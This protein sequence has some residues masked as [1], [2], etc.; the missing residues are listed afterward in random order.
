MLLL[1]V[2]TNAEYRTGSPLVLGLSLKVGGCGWLRSMDAIEDRKPYEHDAIA[3]AIKGSPPETTQPVHADGPE[4]IPQMTE[5]Q[6]AAQ[7]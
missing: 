3:D 2:G 5:N 1:E 7:D 6:G 4:V